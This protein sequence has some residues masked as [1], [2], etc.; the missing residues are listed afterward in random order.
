MGSHPSKSPPPLGGAWAQISQDSPVTRV[1]VY[2]KGKETTKTLYG[3]STD[4]DKVLKKPAESG[5]WTDT[6]DADAS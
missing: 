5:S 3:I 2:P 4:H 6:G 1:Y